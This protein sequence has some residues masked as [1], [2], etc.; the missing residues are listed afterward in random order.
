[1]LAYDNQIDPN[2]CWGL[3]GA[4][5]TLGAGETLTGTN[6]LNSR[7]ELMV[8]AVVTGGSATVYVDFSLDGGATWATQI[9]LTLAD[10][11]S[12]F[13]TYIKGTRTHRV[14]IV[15]GADDL[16]SVQVLTESWVWG[17]VP[18]QGLSTTVQ[19]DSDAS[20]VRPTNANHEVALA[21]RQGA[22]LW[23]KFGYNSDVDTGSAELLAEFGGTFT[24]RTT[25]TTLSIVS[26]S[27]ADDS[28]G[29]GATGIVVYGVD[30]NWNTQTEVVTMDGT[31]PVV[32]TTTWIGINR[33]AIY[34][35]GAGKAN[36]GTITVTAVTG[37]ATMATMPA[38]EGTSQQ[39]IFHVPA[40]T[41]ALIDHMNFSVIRLATGTQPVVTFRV[42]V[43]SAV[44][45]AN[46]RV[47]TF[48]LDGDIENHVIFD[49]QQ[50]L[51]VGEKSTIW[52]EASVT[53]DNTAVAGRMVLTVYENN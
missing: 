35:A 25:G 16:T 5:V 38:G 18:T 34:A 4:T 45:N 13:H 31:T 53:V 22:T 12:D 43:Y 51:I 41:Q 14:R 52:I 48:Y 49:P 50:P 24:P 8:Y 33:I 15:A 17:R 28:G 23:H 39:I 19:K 26:S 7:P 29:T 32:T 47:A 21:R 46:Y 40:D 42:W 10:G 44:S 11:S 9:P 30:E 27:T 2:N 1:M 3:E 37:G 36:A 6:T 20:V